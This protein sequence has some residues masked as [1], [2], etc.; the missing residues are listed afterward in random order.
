MY[1][2]Q[3]LEFLATN[4]SA[5]IVFVFL[6]SLLVGSFLNVV[7]YRV[8]V[9]MKNAW[10]DD[11]DLHTKGEDYVSTRPTFNLIKPDSTCPKCQHK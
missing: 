10:Q 8:P 4:T 3:M 11:I 6:L 9:M 7:I 1:G 2:D 5:Y